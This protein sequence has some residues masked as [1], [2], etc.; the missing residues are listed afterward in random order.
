VSLV[1]GGYKIKTGFSR[2][3]GF[4]KRYYFRNWWLQAIII[5]ERDA[6]RSSAKVN[7]LLLLTV[8]IFP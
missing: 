3:A 6:S 5:L 8:F 1:L 7:N 2:N 4:A